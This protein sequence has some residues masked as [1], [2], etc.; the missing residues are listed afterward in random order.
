[1]RVSAV[2]RS[3]MTA[4]SVGGQAK[5]SLPAGMTTANFAVGDWVLA[6]PQSHKIS[7]RLDRHSLLQ[8]QTVGGGSCN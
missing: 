5:L 2:H 7:R 6:D 3:K 8:R 1:M 4:F